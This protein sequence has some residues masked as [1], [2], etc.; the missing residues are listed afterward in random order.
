LVY[1]A[2]ISG[3]I[4]MAQDINQAL[5]SAAR[6]GQLDLPRWLLDNGVTDPNTKVGVGNTAL[7]YATQGNFPEVAAE[8]CPL[9]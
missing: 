9:D 3:D 8:R 5:T 2:A 1:H 7:A 6:A 4:G